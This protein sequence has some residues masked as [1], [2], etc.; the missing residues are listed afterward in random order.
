M[1]YR[2]PPSGR[3]ADFVLGEGRFIGDDSRSVEFAARPG[4][5]SCILCAR[6]EITEGEFRMTTSAYDCTRSI[7]L[8]RIHPALAVLAALGTVLLVQGCATTPDESGEIHTDKVYRTGSNIPVRDRGGPSD[9]KSY[10]PASV[11]DAVR[12]SGPKTPPGL[13]GG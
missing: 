10:D 3:F 7:R 8:W 9:A 11:E 4:R 5:A 2:S 12:R 6:H 13:R 1:Q